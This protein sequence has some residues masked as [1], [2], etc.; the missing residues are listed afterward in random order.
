MRD[1]SGDTIVPTSAIGNH[2]PLILLAFGGGRPGGIWLG[3]KAGEIRASAPNRN[4][5]AH[6][7]QGKVTNRSL[8]VLIPNFRS[9]S[10]WRPLSMI[11]MG[12]GSGATPPKSSSVISNGRLQTTLRNPGGRSSRLVFG[13]NYAILLRHLKHVRSPQ[14]LGLV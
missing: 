12:D 10:R 14:I 5:Q 6:K 9:S 11:D 2:E 4:E 3:C 8:Y 1:H 13:G 7:K